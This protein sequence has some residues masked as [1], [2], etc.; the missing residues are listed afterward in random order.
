[1]RALHYLYV[2]MAAVCVYVYV[3]ASACVRASNKTICK[4]RHTAVIKAIHFLCLSCSLLT[5]GSIGV[6]LAALESLAV[7]DLLLME[8]KHRTGL[9][10][11]CLR[12]KKKAPTTKLLWLDVC[13]MEFL[14]DVP[15]LNIGY[16][17]TSAAHKNNNLC[18]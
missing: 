17:H 1:M 6:S 13:K 12:K 10:H 11:N 5:A 8:T 18:A 16:H 14:S 4:N 7:D 2:L 9:Q 3:C 15:I